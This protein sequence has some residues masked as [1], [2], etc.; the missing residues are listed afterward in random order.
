MQE[1][2]PTNP[3][4]NAITIP[5]TI[6][7]VIATSPFLQFTAGEGALSIRNRANNIFDAKKGIFRKIDTIDTNFSIFSLRAERD[8]KSGLSPSRRYIC[9]SSERPRQRKIVK[10]CQDAIFLER[11]KKYPREVEKILDQLK[12]VML[13]YG[14]GAYTVGTRALFR[15]VP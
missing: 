8:E 2:Q 4:A 14:E 6:I 7:R 10:S 15:A 5:I 3:M 12:G 11:M 1:R 13:E 9:H